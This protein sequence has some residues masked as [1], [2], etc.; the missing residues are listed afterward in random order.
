L[1]PTMLSLLVPGSGFPPM[2]NTLIA[3]AVVQT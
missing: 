3:C 1:F 2:P